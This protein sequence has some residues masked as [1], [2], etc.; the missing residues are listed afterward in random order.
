[1]RFVV[2]SELVTY[3][4]RL[5]RNR[6]LLTTLVLDDF[7]DQY[8]GTFL[9]LFWAG[10]RP[11]L[12]VGAIWFVFEAGLKGVKLTDGN[13][14]FLLFLLCGYLP[15]L[16]FSESVTGSMNSINS[17]RFLVKQSSFQ[18]SLLPVVKYGSALILHSV[19]LVLLAGILIFHGYSPSRY[20]LQIPLVLFALFPLV[21]GLGWLTSSLRVFSGDVAQVVGL[22]LQVGFWMTPVFWGLERLP[23]DMQE[24]IRINPMVLVV[25]AYRDIFLRGEWVWQSEG[26]LVLY[27]A[28]STIICMLGGLVFKRLRPHFGEVI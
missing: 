11:V 9:G 25:E 14:P 17:K 27:M 12:F 4:S 18:V 24:L 15:W 19:F 8:R 28:I 2:K 23:D 13:H 7:S 5:G 20:W 6:K 10:A 1:M 3:F 22:V 21:L 26:G 16:L